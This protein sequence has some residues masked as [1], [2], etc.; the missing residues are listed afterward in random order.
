MQYGETHAWLSKF[1]QLP[2]VGE[3]MKPRGD[4]IIPIFQ[5]L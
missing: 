2:M 1:S 4:Q 3:E 5:D